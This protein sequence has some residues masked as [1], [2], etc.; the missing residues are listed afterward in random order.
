MIFLM[1]GSNVKSDVQ[2]VK[3]YS[4]SLKKANRNYC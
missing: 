3:E 2:G 4:N 1:S